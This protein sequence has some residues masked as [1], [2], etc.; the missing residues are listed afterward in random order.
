MVCRLNSRPNNNKKERRDNMAI[1][2]R[3][4]GLQ[5]IC[6]AVLGEYQAKGFRLVEFGDHALTLYYHDERVGVLSQRGATIAM[7]HEACR[8]YLAG[9]ES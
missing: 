4:Q 7:I 9:L 3:E 5:S 6:N 1:Y 8:E 2:N